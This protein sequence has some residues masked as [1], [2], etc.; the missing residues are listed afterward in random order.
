MSTAAGNAKVIEMPGGRIAYEVSGEGPLVVL[1]HGMGDNRSVYRFL[2]P[3]LAAAGYRVAA[4]DLR[5]H[6]ESSTGW[7]SYTHADIAGD[8][9]AV[10][11]TEGGPAVIVGHSCSGGAATVAAGTHPDRVTAV[12]EIGPATR[13]YAMSAAALLRNRR[14]RRGF[15]LLARGAFL[16]S[17][18]AW[19]KY[20]DH[21]YPGAKPADWDAWLA[22]LLAGLRE[23]GRMRPVRA[24]GTSPAAG[25]V[26]QLPNVRCPA[27][28]IMG[29]LDPDWPDPR[30]EATAITGLLPAG[31]GRHVMIEGAGHY[32]HAQYPAQ[33]AEAIL[34]FLAEGAAKTAGVRP[35]VGR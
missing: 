23:D 9:L 6:G 25:T 19:G 14:Y 30:A 28:I 16:G 34:A 1:S 31:T 22:T 4:V 7:A 2:A 13:P 20:L 18:G 29:T 26:A 35:P 10:I 11:A 27:L 21:A 17:V 8:L 3:L 5:G 33:T 12:V 32:P 15:L 24:I